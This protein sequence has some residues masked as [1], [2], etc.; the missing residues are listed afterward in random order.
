MRETS[1]PDYPNE[2]KKLLCRPLTLDKA[3][4]CGQEIMLFA[5]PT[6]AGQNSQP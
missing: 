3:D 2:D 1:G 6:L 5:P 4:N